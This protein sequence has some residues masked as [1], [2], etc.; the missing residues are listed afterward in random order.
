MGFVFI[1]LFAID[2]SLPSGAVPGKNHFSIRFTFVTQSELLFTI[3][4]EANTLNP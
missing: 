4:I 1:Y 2:R 3:E